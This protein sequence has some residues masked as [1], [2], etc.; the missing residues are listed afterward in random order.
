[1][2]INQDFNELYPGREADLI[3][4]WDITADFIVELVRRETAKSDSYTLI[5][6][7]EYDQHPNKNILIKI[8]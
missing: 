8:F 1:M 2:Q 4:K 6:L 5:Q 3:T 7:K